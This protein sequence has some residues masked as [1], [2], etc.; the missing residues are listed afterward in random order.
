MPIKKLQIGIIGLG[1]WGANILKNVLKMPDINLASVATSKTKVIEKIPKNTKIFRDWKELIDNSNLDGVIIS[2]PA[3]THFEIACKSLKKG[4]NTLVEK[5][6]TINPNEAAIIR[7]ISIEKK[8]LLMTEFTQVFNPK[9]QEMKKNLYLA[10][11]LN[12]ICTE[13]GNF[14]PIRNKTPVLFDWGSHELSILI[15]L[16]G[17]LPNKINARKINENSNKNGEESNWEIICEFKNNLKTKSIIGN[18]KEKVRRTTVY[19]D[20]GV[21]YLNDIGENSLQ[22]SN[23][24]NLNEPYK[25]NIK[26]IEI[27]DKSEP[28]LIA[29]KSFFDAIR[30][31]EYNHWSLNLGV[32]ITKLL[33]ECI[34]NQ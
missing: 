29:L 15:S 32:E 10:G 25:E 22:F 34:T 17:Y 5:P 13:A 26:L 24:K 4:I 12:N 3:E 9:F 2:T 14:G 19:G 7:N 33:S 27:E 30:N 23:S 6:L 31:K 21:L 18:Y 16:L 8:I 1:R 11:N 20:K 28:L